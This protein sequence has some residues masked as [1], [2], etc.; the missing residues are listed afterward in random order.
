MKLVHCDLLFANCYPEFHFL[1]H[2]PEQRLVSPQVSWPEAPELCGPRAVSNFNGE[3]SLG[4]FH[5]V[6]A[7]RNIL[8]ADDWPGKCYGFSLR[9][10]P[11]DLFHDIAQTC[12]G[13]FHC[14]AILAPRT[15]G[16]S[17]LTEIAEQDL[18]ALDAMT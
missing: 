10:G 11:Q 3:T 2:R 17:T 13:G 18:A 15:L 16:P 9:P 14:I 12:A 5:G 8:P 7:L 4:K 6:S 1:D